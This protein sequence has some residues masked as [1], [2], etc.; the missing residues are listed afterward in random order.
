MQLG[1][2]RHI[3]AG[4]G[5]YHPRIVTQAA[6]WRRSGSGAWAC[7]HPD[8]PINTRDPGYKRSAIPAVFA[9]SAG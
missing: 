6:L 1:L 7:G 4:P 9:A 3:E 2:D 5:A 8:E